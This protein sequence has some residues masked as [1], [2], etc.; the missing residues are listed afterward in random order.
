MNNK[1]KNE[2]IAKLLGFEKKTFSRGSLKDV[3]YWVYPKEFR[4][5]RAQE[6]EYHVPDFLKIIEEYIEI[7][8]KL[9]Y[10]YP[11]MYNF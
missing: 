9:N 11:R 10:S 2:E 6:P 5:M 3:E 1:E 4:V 8:E 7:K